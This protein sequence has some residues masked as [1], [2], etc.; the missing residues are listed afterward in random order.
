MT[1]PSGDHC[2]FRSRRRAPE[3]SPGTYAGDHVQGLIGSGLPTPPDAVPPPR[4]TAAPLDDLYGFDGPPVAIGGS[5]FED[6]VRQGRSILEGTWLL[7]DAADRMELLAAEA[8]AEANRAADA[9]QVYLFL[10]DRLRL[11][12]SS[13]PDGDWAD[14]EPGALADGIDG[15]CL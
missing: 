8:R 3:G 5:A 13:P 6:R 14:D 9:A 11:L 15:A 4:V 12:A 10:A 7:L 1:T 2:R